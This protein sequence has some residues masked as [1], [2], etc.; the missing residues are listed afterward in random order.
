MNCPNCQSPMT[1]ESHVEPDAAGNGTAIRPH[2]IYT[3]EECGF[4]GIWRLGQQLE[5]TY[6]PREDRT[7]LY[8]R[9]D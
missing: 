5:I 2:A 7:P 3:C 1:H 4:E 9:M 8:E 6:D